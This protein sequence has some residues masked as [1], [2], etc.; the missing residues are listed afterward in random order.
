MCQPQYLQSVNRRSEDSPRK[1]A[2]KK[3]LLISENVPPQVNGIA[4]RIGYYHQG[5]LDLG[6]DVDF[7]HPESGLDKC[8]PHVNPYNF[9]AKMMIILPTY[10]YQLLSTKYDTVHAVMP[11]NMSGMWLLAAF[12]ALRCLRGESSPALVISWH[13]NM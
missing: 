1:P 12:K 10:F 11:L 3:I 5:L 6:Y 7:L 2:P 9:T 4:R 8:I 13:C